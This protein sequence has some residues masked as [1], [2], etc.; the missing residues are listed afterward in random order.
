MDDRTLSS[1]ALALGVLATLASGAW[2]ITGSTVVGLVT[3][4][5]LIAVIGALLIRLARPLPNEP[6]SEPQET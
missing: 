5:G 3:I 2:L 1:L 4:G 6:E